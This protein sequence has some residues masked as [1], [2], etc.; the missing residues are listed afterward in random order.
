MIQQMIDP[1]CNGLDNAG[2]S[3]PIGDKQQPI[4]A[5]KIALR[6]LQNDNRIVVHKSSTVPPSI[7]DPAPTS[8]VTKVS[9][10]KRPTSERPTSPACHLSPNN[11]NG[12][13]VY[14]R[15][16]S[17]QEVA[18]G[19]NCENDTNKTINSPQLSQ[20]I[21]G[22]KETTRQHI[23]VQGQK[24][25]CVPA[26]PPMPTTA[27]SGGPSIPHPHGMPVNMSATVGPTCT[28][29]VLPSNTQRISDQNWKERFP[30]LQMFLRNCDH[31]SQEEYIQMLKSLSSVGRS[32]H[33]VELEKRAIQLLLEEGKELNRMKLL[34]VLGKPSSKNFPTT[35]QVNSRK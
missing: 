32:R 17:D 12:T 7:K 2:T 27:S 3:F 9:G 8:D 35:P 5:K 15:R 18:K 34:N 23:Q 25:S 14:I 16:K 10:A 19:N 6:D 29:D 33:A 21:Q 26:A 28:T 13:F 31:S 1:K 4:A 24:N 11:A 20:N 22:E 30:H